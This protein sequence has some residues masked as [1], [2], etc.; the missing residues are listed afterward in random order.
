MIIAP[1]VYTVL[2]IQRFCIY[3]ENSVNE[4]RISAMYWANDVRNESG[5]ASVELK[6]MWK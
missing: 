4:Y 2:I 1:N 3:S 5:L 6:K